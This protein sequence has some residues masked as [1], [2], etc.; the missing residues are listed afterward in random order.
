MCVQG[1]EMEAAPA[2]LWRGAGSFSVTRV[3]AAGGQPGRQ[4][5]ATE[6][7]LSPGGCRAAT[8]GKARTRG[9]QGDNKQREGAALQAPVSCASNGHSAAPPATS[10]LDLS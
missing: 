2:K 1:R 6:T 3:R 7:P 8:A 10:A 4:L 5:Q 9:F